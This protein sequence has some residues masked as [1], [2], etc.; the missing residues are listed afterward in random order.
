MGRSSVRS[1]VDQALAQA[2]Y[3]GHT[4]SASAYDLIKEA[5]Q[6]AD[7]QEFIAL[8][9]VD[10]GTVAGNL[11][12]LAVADYIKR[13]DTSSIPGP[14]ESAAP[15]GTQPIPASAS[16]KKILPL[17]KKDGDSPEETE[18]P[19]GVQATIGQ[20][21]GGTKSAGYTLLDLISKHADAADI[22]G[23]QESIALQDGGAAPPRRNENT[24]IGLLR[25]EDAI[26]NATPR[27]AH[28]PTRARLAQLFAHAND[29]GQSE[30]IARRAFP[31]AYAGGGGVKAASATDY[32]AL[33]ELMASGALGEDAYDYAE[34]IDAIGQQKIA[35]V[36]GTALG[37]AAGGLLAGVP[38]TAAALAA[39]VGQQR[40]H[41]KKI[42]AGWIKRDS[43]EDRAAR[44]RMFRNTI[45]A[46][47]APLALGMG[48]GG[49]GGYKAHRAAES[50]AGHT[51]GTA[52]KAG[53]EEAIR[54][55][56]GRVAHQAAEAAEQAY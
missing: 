15:T 2:R 35:A 39:H 26:L 3:G 31:Q 21:P 5:H 1:I 45:I 54:S 28:A 56:F 24:N 52:S 41:E 14:A 18:A 20:P 50:V 33:F 25:S 34:Y 43:D 42:D 47:A 44:K 49:L 53:I 51:I 7:A 8:S 17:G 16:N 12:K 19:T 46:G 13:A 22:P 4:K 23:P 48:L 29:N 38:A 10:D 30:D 27:Q 6:L 55:R 40:A 36:A 9:A 32:H 11:R 37:A